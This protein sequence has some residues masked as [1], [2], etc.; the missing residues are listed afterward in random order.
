MGKRTMI[1]SPFLGAAALEEM[2]QPKSQD[3]LVSRLEALQS[4][5]PEALGCFEQIYYLNDAAALSAETDDTTSEMQGLHAKIYVTEEG[6]EAWIWT[7]SSNATQAGMNGNVEFLAGLKGKRSAW[8]I[9][10]ILRKTPGEHALSDLL[11]PF[12]PGESKPIEDPDTE[13]RV[14]GDTLR[15]ALAEAGLSIKVEASGEDRFFLRLQGKLPSDAVVTAA[16]LRCWPIRLGETRSLSMTD[17]LAG[18]PFDLELIEI[19]SFIAIDAHFTRGGRS[20]TERF[21]INLPVS[22]MPEGRDD[23]ILRDILKDKARVLRLLMFLLSGDDPR[24]LVRLIAENPAEHRAHSDAPGLAGFPLFENLL[25]SLHREPGRLEHVAKL[26]NDLS[27][28]PEGE[29]LI[30]EEFMSIWQPVW[31][32]REELTI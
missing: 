8:G 28:T 14:A 13:L 30:P 22:G 9:D 5:T 2:S 4:L 16:T 20:R 23:A 26:L 11:V 18:E 17:A 6:A 19:S 1:V 25:R 3:V 31:E 32:A 15:R 21:V 24:E 29:A 12:E 10:A 27:R 7:G